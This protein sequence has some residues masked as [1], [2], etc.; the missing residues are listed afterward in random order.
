MA[1]AARAEAARLRVP[2]TRR[3]IMA[4]ILDGLAG[5]G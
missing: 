3:A 1:A 5:A 2:A 4:R